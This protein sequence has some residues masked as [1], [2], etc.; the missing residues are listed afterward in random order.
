VVGSWRLQSVD[1][2]TLPFTIPEEQSGGADKLEVTAEVIAFR[3][4]GPTSHTFVYLR[5]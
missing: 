2:R 3:V 4:T 5:D 1:G